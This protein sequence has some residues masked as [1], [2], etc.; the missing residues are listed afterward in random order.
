MQVTCAVLCK[1]RLI[2]WVIA[3][4]GICDAIKIGSHD[5][6][7]PGFYLKFNLWKKFEIFFEILPNVLNAKYFLLEL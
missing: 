3:L 5:G 2:L 1:I 7:C 4:L 6:C